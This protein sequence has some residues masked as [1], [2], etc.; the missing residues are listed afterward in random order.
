M[1]MM[2]ILMIMKSKLLKLQFGREKEKE[3]EIYKK[4][5]EIK[6]IYWRNFLFY[7]YNIFIKNLK[8]LCQNTNYIFTN[9]RNFKYIIETKWII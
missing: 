9:K 8:I 2:M 4:E 7:N 5:K 1:E 3:R 6:T